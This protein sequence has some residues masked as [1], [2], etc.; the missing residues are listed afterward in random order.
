MK[1]I[2]TTHATGPYVL[3]GEDEAAVIVAG[4]GKCPVTIEEEEL[5]RKLVT[6]FP[7]LTKLLP[8]MGP[9]L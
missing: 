8:L 1:A 6:A 4:I 2:D 5:V 9:L 3:I 7:H